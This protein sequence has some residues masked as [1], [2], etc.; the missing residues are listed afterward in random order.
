MTSYALGIDL[1]TSSIAAAIGRGSTWRAVPVDPASALVSTVGLTA[2]DREQLAVAIARPVRAAIDRAT[3]LE[4]GAP[5]IVVLAHGTRDADAD[6]LAARA[7]ELAGVPAEQLVL[8]TRV[9]AAA[10]GDEHAAMRLGADGSLAV[11]SGA[12][13]AGAAPL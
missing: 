1:G 8:L 9:A 7:G 11:A 5:T 2:N 12:A 3:R 4:G 6:A 10:L 13:L